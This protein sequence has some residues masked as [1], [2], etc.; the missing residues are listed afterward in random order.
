MS[1]VMKF[2]KKMFLLLMLFVTGNTSIAFGGQLINIYKDGKPIN[3]DI[4]A[5]ILKTQ[6]KR[7][8]DDLAYQFNAYVSYKSKQELI[9][10]NYN[11]DQIFS[12]L[13]YVEFQLDR[14]K[15]NEVLVLWQRPG[16]CGSGGCSGL[17]FKL[18][19]EQPKYLG[20]VF[21]SGLILT[22]TIGPGAGPDHGF[23]DFAISGDEG[24]SQYTFNPKKGYYM[25]KK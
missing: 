22:P 14:S 1:K 7:I 10:W 25:P 9:G 15:R 16:Y 2:S 24:I 21:L 23:H 3:G 18:D 11:T 20:Q 12:D 5:A 17:I 4:K 13:K 8:V 19:T 6:G